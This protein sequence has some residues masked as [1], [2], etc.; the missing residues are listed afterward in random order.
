MEFPKTDIGGV[1][2]RAKNRRS[3]IE[4]QGLP[5]EQQGLPEPNRRGNQWRALFWPKKRRFRAIRPEPFA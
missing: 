3:R 4:D 1:E 5:K 2:S